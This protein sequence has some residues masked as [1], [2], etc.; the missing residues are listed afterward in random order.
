MLLTKDEPGALD[1]QLTIAS[2]KE[3]LQKLVNAGFNPWSFM[4]KLTS[5]S[6]DKIRLFQKLWQE[7]NLLIY[8]L[9]WLP[10]LNIDQKQ[11]SIKEFKDAT[12]QIMQVTNPAAF[13][14][15]FSSSGLVIFN[16]AE[17]EQQLVL[18]LDQ[19]EHLK[20][21]V[22]EAIRKQAAS[23]WNQIM[24]LDGKKTV[25]RIKSLVLELLDLGVKKVDHLLLLGDYDLSFL[26]NKGVWD[27]VPLDQLLSGIEI[28]TENKNIVITSQLF[29]EQTTLSLP[30]NKINVVFN[31]LTLKNVESI[32]RKI[33]SSQKD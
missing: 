1:F 10:V 32:L 24:D 27:G 7:Q 25:Q 23:K 20:Q 9:F 26:Q 6:Q 22:K 18:L 14:Q 29:P 13:A 3:L 28:K 19:N 11:L 17:S 21:V 31:L 2:A 5:L 33:I 15:L 12:V 4:A 30:F 8:D 16:L